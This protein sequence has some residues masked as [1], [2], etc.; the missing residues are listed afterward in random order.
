MVKHLVGFPGSQQCNTISYVYPI[1]PASL[2][3]SPPPRQH[4]LVTPLL[5]NPYPRTS[6]PETSTKTK[7]ESIAEIVHVYIHCLIH[8]SLSL[9][10]KHTHAHTHT[11]TQMY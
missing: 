6:L 2:P 7:I 8:L 3:T 11:H 1:L 10:H 4:V 9:S 5:L